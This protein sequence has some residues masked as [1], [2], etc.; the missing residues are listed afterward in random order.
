M[1]KEN[2]QFVSAWLGANKVIIFVAVVLKTRKGTKIYVS[3]IGCR[4]KCQ[5]EEISKRPG[6]EEFKSTRTVR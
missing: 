3:V 6:L 4:E 5:T 2:N 1:F